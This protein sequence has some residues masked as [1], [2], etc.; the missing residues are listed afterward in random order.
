M[1]ATEWITMAT[2][3]GGLTLLLACTVASVQARRARTLAARF[4]LLE[5]RVAEL[6]AGLAAGQALGAELAAQVEQLKL[7]L[8]RADGTA[9]RLG[10][11]EAI[12]LSRRG[13]DAHEIV[14]TCGIGYGEARLIGLMHGRV[15]AEAGKAE[16]N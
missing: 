5:G 12:A 1:N 16:P 3:G 10:L 2:A 14:A 11:R 7:Q 8:G 15:Q 13:A 4:A 9:L 6:G